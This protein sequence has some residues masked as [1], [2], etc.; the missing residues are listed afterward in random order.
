MI[1]RVPRT[2]APPVAALA[3]IGGAGAAAPRLALINESPS[4]PKGLYVRSFAAA[5][6]DG[7]VV[8]IPQP[9]G[10]RPY[11]AG[12]GVPL[13]T[14]LLKRVAASGGAEVCA[15]PNA[16]LVGSHPLSTATVDRRGTRLPRW[17]GCRRLA[18]GELF[19]VGDTATSFDSRYF[20]PVHRSQVEG[21][22]REILTW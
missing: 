8:A 13:E 3:L 14:K 10:A 22:Y 4:L 21:V 12:L 16:V 2:L 9:P 18:P 17:S 5:L 1:R 15:K 20:G 11:R 7:A 19:L 6:A